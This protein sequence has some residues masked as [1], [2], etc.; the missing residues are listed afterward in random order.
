MLFTARAIERIPTPEKRATYHDVQVRDLGLRVEATGRKCFF[1]FRKV[2]GRPTFKLVGTF[3]QT[4]VQ[5]ARGM[6]MELSGQ[7]DKFRRNDYQTPNPFQDHRTEPTLGRLFEQYTA[8]QLRQ[9]AKRAEAAE[10]EARYVFKHMSAWSDRKLGHITRRDVLD[11]HA[12][13]GEKHRT[14]A[15]RVLQLLKAMYGFAQRTEMWSGQNPAMGVKLF[16]EE[17]RTRFVQPDELPRLFMALRDE[18]SADLR[19]FV[20]LCLWTGA[21]KSDV[22]SMRWENVWLA[23]N[24]WDIPDPKNNEP[25][26]VP[27]TPEAVSILSERLKV[28][29]EGNPWVFPSSGKSGHVTDLKK[30]WHALLERAG[31]ED[32]HIHD[33]RRTLGSWQA[34]Q[35]SSL[36][37]IGKSLGHKSTA[38]TQIYARLNLDPVRASVEAATRAMIVAGAKEAKALE[39]AKA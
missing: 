28:R 5:E 36:L 38:A 12:D 22:L 25:Y 14:Q 2:L 20:L 26:P 4:S 35:G 34:A 10:R 3:P 7:L 13:I 39:A 17:K 18:P 37:V 11:L 9:Y 21:R 1:W 15:N 29:R 31:I 8:M 16:H 33:L 6:A 32:L 23:D 24:R 30:R 19:D 27:L